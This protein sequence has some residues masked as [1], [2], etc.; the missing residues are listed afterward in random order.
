[1]KSMRYCTSAQASERS[2]WIRCSALVVFVLMTTLT[3]ESAWLYEG[4]YGLVALLLLT[5]L[6]A[7]AQP[8]T[9]PLAWF[10]RWRPL[11]GLGLISYGVY[12]WHWPIGLWV[13]ADNTG[14]DGPAL[15]FVRCALTLAAALASYF[16]VEMPI[17]RGALSRLGG[18][19]R[20][21]VPALTVVALL[22]IGLWMNGGFDARLPSDP[23][24]RRAL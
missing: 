14:F 24:P 15:F 23:P 3:T 1:M 9:N 20:K 17:R 6:A 19:T 22:M 7:A 13:N 4:G 16:L 10:L 2:C 11:V 18:V 5:V 21:V 8:G 12:L